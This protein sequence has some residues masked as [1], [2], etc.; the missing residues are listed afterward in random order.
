[1]KAIVLM[2]ALFPSA[3]MHA[4]EGYQVGDKAASFTL[5][6][7]DGKMISLADYSE[8]KGFVV[9]FT[10]NHCPYAKAYQDRLISI[11]KKYRSKGY[12]VIAV[13]PNDRALQPEDSFEAMKTRAKEKGYTFPYLVDEK[14]DVYKM[15]G[16]SRTPHVYLLQKDPSGQL[17]VKY[18]GAIDD[19][20]QDANSVK[21][22]YL[23][24]ALNALLTGKNPD[25]SFTKAIGCGIKSKQ[26]A[27]Q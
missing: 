16:A 22:P 26:T 1:M 21:Q 6:N 25:P 17:W 3:V 27:Q 5:K 12:P 20:H 24:N 18:I 8:A 7:V 9:V 23:E 19:N 10:C 13:N 15:Y 11:D 4:G 2:I 14:Q